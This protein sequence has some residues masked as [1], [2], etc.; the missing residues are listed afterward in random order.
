MRVWR[1]RCSVVRSIL[2]VLTELPSSSICPLFTLR[3]HSAQSVWMNECATTTCSYRLLVI[4]AA[5][6]LPL[7]LFLPTT[8]VDPCTPSA[9][10]PYLV[11]HLP[12]CL[13]RLVVLPLTLQTAATA[14]AT[15][16]D[17]LLP[18]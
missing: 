8:T 18:V 4:V 17:S 12:L 9:V 16:D 5:F 1:V 7:F 14:A 11:L 10:S 2:L 6:L 13:L 15:T 3:P